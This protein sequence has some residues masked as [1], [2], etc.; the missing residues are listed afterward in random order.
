LTTKNVGPHFGQFFPNSAGRWTHGTHGWHP[1]WNCMLCLFR[2][3]MYSGSS[4]VCE[5][6]DFLRNV[7]FVTLGSIVTEPTRDRYYDL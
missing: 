2:E 1:E 7:Y 4:H 3:D 5:E 6:I